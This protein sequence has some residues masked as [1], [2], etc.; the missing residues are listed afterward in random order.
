MADGYT[1]TDVDEDGYRALTADG[2]AVAIA[3]EA[4]LS[5]LALVPLSHFIDRSIADLIASFLD[6][7]GAPLLA[8]GAHG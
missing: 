1:L 5:L 2:S 8:N 3:R 7:D 6:A 4:T